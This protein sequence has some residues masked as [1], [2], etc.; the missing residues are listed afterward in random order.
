MTDMA[1][2]TNNGVNYKTESTSK[3][4]TIDKKIE[5][6]VISGIET[7]KAYKGDVI[8]VIEFSDINYSSYSITLTRTHIDTDNIDETDESKI[9]ENINA[10]VTEIFIPT[11]KRVITEQNGK[12]VI[13][14]L[15][16]ENV[17]NDGIYNLKVEITDKAGNTTEE[18]ITFTL[19][20]FGSV[21]SYDEYL[22]SLIEDRYIKKV[23]EDIV[24]TEYNADEIS[25]SSIEVE[26]TRDGKPLD[27]VKYDI[28]PEVNETVQIGET[29]WYQCEYRID[30]SNF[31]QDG[32]Y[33]MA[34]FSKDKNGNT[35]ENVPDRTNH[36]Q[37]LAVFSVDSTSPEITSISGLEEKIINA[38]EVNVNYD[39]FDAIGLASIQIYL[40]D[41]KI[42]IDGDNLY[43]LNNYS[44]SF[45]VKD[46]DKQQKVRMVVT[47]YAGNSVDT[48]SD[49]F[50]K[51][52][53]YA[54][55]NRITVSTDFWVRFR[56]NKVA[57]WGSVLGIIVIIA[58]VTAGVIFFRKK[59]SSAEEENNVQN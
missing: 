13:D 23:N 57:V 59:K 4:F 10:D 25:N 29:G 36:K 7:G 6:P 3:S 22:I 53:K 55:N 24:I 47:D 26:I 42:T 19:N 2:N 45:V 49:D 8:P 51:N 12:I 16:E 20:R 15:N 52:C 34:V 17:N 56:A 35:S 32:V 27:E 1:G 58:G 14:T 9:R 54:F 43:D 11:E 41:D 21:F 18:N 39:V 40:N 44:G 37:N 33:K 30:A 48:D 38:Q 46:S 31:K 28:T 5:K 50:S